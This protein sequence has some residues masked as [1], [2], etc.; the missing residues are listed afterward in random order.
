MSALGAVAGDFGRFSRGLEATVGHLAQAADHIEG[1]AAVDG[2]LSLDQA[3][4]RLDSTLHS[5]ALTSPIGGRRV[6]Q[7]ALGEIGGELAHTAH[8]TILQVT[9]A[10]PQD[11]SAIA[12]SIR[13][14]V[15]KLASVDAIENPAAHG[16][17][18][19]EAFTGVHL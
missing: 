3:G 4:S 16:A 11:F 12:D 5:R 17:S 8:S 15:I 9:G 1:G 13:A 14:T 6:A 7:E 2:M 19:I 18:A 10:G